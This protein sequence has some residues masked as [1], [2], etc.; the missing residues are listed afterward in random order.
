[1]QFG[2]N[3]HQCL[4]FA[5]VL[6]EKCNCG[7]CVACRSFFKFTDLHLVNVLQLAVNSADD[8]VNGNC[9]CDSSEHTHCTVEHGLRAGQENRPSGVQLTRMERFPFLVCYKVD[10]LTRIGRWNFFSVV[11]V[12]LHASLG[13]R[14]MQ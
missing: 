4:N 11:S 2:V 8:D 12:S 7:I 10:L 14:L 9:D 13:R 3:K 6:R 1:M 5:L